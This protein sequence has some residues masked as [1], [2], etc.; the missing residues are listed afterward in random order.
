MAPVTGLGLALV[1]YA[2]YAISVLAAANIRPDV[3]QQE[4]SRRLVTAPPGVGSE[5]RRR[6][7]H[8][9]DIGN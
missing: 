2:A 9:S 4:L 1:A 7:T 5:V 6:A 3:I 8:G